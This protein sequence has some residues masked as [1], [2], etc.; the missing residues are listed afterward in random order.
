MVSWFKWLPWFGEAP[1]EEGTS[2]LPMILFNQLRALPQ[3]NQTDRPKWASMFG[4]SRRE[5]AE[6][7]RIV[8]FVKRG[9][10]NNLIKT[11]SVWIEIHIISSD[12]IYF[13]TIFC[14]VIKN[15]KDMML[16]TGL[17]KARCIFIVCFSFLL[18]LGD[19]FLFVVVV[20]VVLL[21]LLVL[22]IVCAQLLC[23]SF[24]KWCRVYR[25]LRVD[26]EAWFM[27]C[28]WFLIS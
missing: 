11:E 9:S 20:V 26:V 7:S 3:W 14:T 17:L 22:L 2:I 15:L 24:G 21:L 5:N 1:I 4:I 8:P 19:L 6:K 13:K 28:W 23:S 25:L 12:Y 10:C 18:F 16:L 27:C